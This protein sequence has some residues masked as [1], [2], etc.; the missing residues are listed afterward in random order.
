M[1]GRA[2]RLCPGRSDV[3]LFNYGQGIVDLDAKIPH[4]AFDFRVAKQ[5]L[6]SSQIAGASINQCSLG[7]SEAIGV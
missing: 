3:N 7:S 5:E 6:D 4:G 2:D 1:A